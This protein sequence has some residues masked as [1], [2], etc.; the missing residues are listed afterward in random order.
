M[1]EKLDDQMVALEDSVLDHPDSQTSN[2]I[3][4]LRRALIILRR[5]IVPLREVLSSLLRAEN[6]FV[7]PQTRVYFRDLYDHTI[8]VVEMLEMFR[9]MVSGIRDIYF[10]A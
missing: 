10:R 6:R 7:K 1:L 4:S 3:H 9:E 2:R 5:S 8:E